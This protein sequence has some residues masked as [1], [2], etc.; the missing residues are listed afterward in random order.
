MNERIAKHDSDSED[1]LYSTV[2][3]RDTSVDIKH[4][5]HEEEH[6]DAD[7]STL[8]TKKKL[9]KVT[10]HSTKKKLQGIDNK[11]YVVKICSGVTLS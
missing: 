10:L 1:P 4:R 8:R 2:K 6:Q 7:D 11:G 5:Q 3:P 9:P